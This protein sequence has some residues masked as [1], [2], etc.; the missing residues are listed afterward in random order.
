MRSS[1]A[2]ALASFLRSKESGKRKYDEQQAG[3]GVRES[4]F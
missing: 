4:K 2:W 1:D 3:P